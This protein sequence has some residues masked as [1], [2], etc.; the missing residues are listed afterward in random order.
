MA[1]RQ[2][3]LDDRKKEL[4]IYIKLTVYIDTYCAGPLEVKPILGELE[5]LRAC[6]DVVGSLASPIVDSDLLE[7]LYD[8]AAE[9]PSI[10]PAV[11][12]GAGE[13]HSDPAPSADPPWA[14]RVPNSSCRDIFWRKCWAP[15]MPQAGSLALAGAITPSQATAPAASSLLA[16]FVSKGASVKSLK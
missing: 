4:R 6:R 10:Y 3:M 5:E 13:Q 1:Q 12:S 15:P 16:L 8:W 9:K 11:C 2:A 7:Q 14:G